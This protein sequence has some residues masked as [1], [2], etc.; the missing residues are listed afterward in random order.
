[1]SYDVTSH[2]LYSVSSKNFIYAYHVDLLI[3]KIILDVH[4]AFHG[5]DIG[6]LTSTIVVHP[7]KG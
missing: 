1:M 3:N 2:M 4:D 7:E 6:N 5:D